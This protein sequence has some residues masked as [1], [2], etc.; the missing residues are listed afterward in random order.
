MVPLKL[1]ITGISQ[2]VRNQIVDTKYTT[3]FKYN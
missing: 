3:K 2:L 1:N